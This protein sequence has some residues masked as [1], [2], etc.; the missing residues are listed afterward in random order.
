MGPENGGRRGAL[1]RRL[2]GGVALRQDSG[3]GAAWEEAE[4]R[5]GPSGCEGPRGDV[6]EAK[7]SQAQGSGEGPG[8][9]QRCGGP[10][11]RRKTEALGCAGVMPQKEVSGEAGGW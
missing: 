6:Q 1:L 3:R 5:V 7:E 11:R 9:G 10:Q 4:A 8:P 2:H